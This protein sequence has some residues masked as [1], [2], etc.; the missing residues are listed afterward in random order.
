MAAGEATL[1]SPYLTLYPLDHVLASAAAQVAATCALRGADAVYVAT[2][3]H[4]NAILITLDVEVRERASG[5]IAVRT[6]D[7]WSS[8]AMRY[9]TG[10]GT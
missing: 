7:E 2:A 9:A 5:V 1:A 4:A 3:R 6:P 8:D 10:H